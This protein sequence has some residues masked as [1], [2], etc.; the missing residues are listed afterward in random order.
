M[1]TQPV[2]TVVCDR[3]DLE[4]LEVVYGS[5]V[6]DQLIRAGWGV[7]GGVL[8]ICKRCLDKEQEQ[9]VASCGVTGHCS[10]DQAI[11]LI[12]LLGAE[13]RER[14]RTWTRSKTAMDAVSYSCCLWWLC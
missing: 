2:L 12:A 7:G 1:R 8:D 9:A 10:E 4:E 5:D 13:Y 11:R 14:K 6:R 3:C